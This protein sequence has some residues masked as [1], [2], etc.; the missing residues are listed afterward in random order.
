MHQQYAVD[1]GVGQRQLVLVHQGGERRTIR[2]PFHH[3]L[4]GRHE[5]ETALRFVAKQPE[6][7]GGIA[8]PQHAQAV[9]IGPA[10]ADAAADEPACHHAERLAVEIAQI[11]DVERHGQSLGRGAR[12][13]NHLQAIGLSLRRGA[14]AC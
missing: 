11:D 5:G 12:P 8:D 6:V 10:R 1:R 9:Q 7:R 3:A 14:K 2:G 13:D 4:R